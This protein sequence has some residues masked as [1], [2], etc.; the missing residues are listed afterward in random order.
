MACLQSYCGAC[1][2][3]FCQPHRGKV[4]PAQ[5]S[6]DFVLAI[7]VH[8]PGLHRMIP[9]C[10][11]K[12]HHGC[13]TEREYEC[14]VTT[15]KWEAVCTSACSR[16]TKRMPHRLGRVPFLY[17][18]VPS[19]SLLSSASLSLHHSS[20]AADCSRPFCPEAVPAGKTPSTVEEQVRQ[21][22]HSWLHA[23][24]VQANHA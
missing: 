5:L 18:S 4:S 1:L 14:K 17:P 8:I 3:V 22:R 13:E 12:T 11:M 16:F 20:L 6:D 24:F 2:G 15:T 7:L 9:S 23:G 21:L 10:N 19:S